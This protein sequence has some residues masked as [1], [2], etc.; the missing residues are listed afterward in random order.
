MEIRRIGMG[1]YKNFLE[2]KVSSGN[3]KKGNIGNK[4]TTRVEGVTTEISLSSVS[5]RREE[6]IEEIKFLIE[7]G[8]YKIDS[9]SI[10]KNLIE[11]LIND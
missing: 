9:S 11:E 3:Q 1:V 10:S 8:L 5:Q 6:R 2:E 4:S 7:K